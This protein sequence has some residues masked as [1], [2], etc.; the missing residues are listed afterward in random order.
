[1][2]TRIPRSTALSYGVGSIGTGV[3]STVPG[4][5]LLFYLTDLVGVA[6]GVASLVLLLPKL[7]DAVLNPFVGA[8]SD[9]VGARRPFLLVGAVGVPV[10]FALLFSAPDLGSPGATALY[11]GVV[12]LL[13]MTAFAFFQVP[14]VAMPAEMTD[15]YH[16][17][18]RL[19]SV[20]MVLLTVGILVGGALAPALAG[21]KEGGRDGYARMSL[22]VAVVL[23]AAL[24]TAWRGTRGVPTAPPATGPRVTLG[25][26]LRV[27]RGN[28]AF[29][30][31]FTGYALQAVATGAML[32]GAPYVATYVLDDSG[33][34]SVLFVCLV[35]PAALVMPAWRRLSLRTGKLTG[36]LLASSLF[37]LAAAWLV[38][39]RSLPTAGVLLLTAVLG[40]GYAGMQ[41][42]PY[43]MLPDAL[44]AD[45][46]A[47]GEA[48]A[49]TY[50]GVWQAGETIGFAL[51]PALY[52]VTLALSGFTSS[53]AD[54]RVAQTDGAVTGV[55]LGFTLLPAV[56]VLLSLPVLRRCRSADAGHAA[57]TPA[58]VLA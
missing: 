25:A 48:R 22:V 32:A 7:W 20:R 46:S 17:R 21:G 34:A 3:Y 5:L 56:V 18:T 33:L 52:A 15:D 42:F 49:G 14:Y 57:A 54:E 27:V 35:A 43:A 44:A 41:L 16:E 37:A 31:L 8:W 23:A 24:L 47:A 6:A 45:Q 9:R 26:Q 28:P 1:M 10:L 55:V 4:L 29:L 58:G 11:V 12:Y 40:V 30:A 38:L 51:G 13:A 53:P 50:T 39:A 19:M 36:Y 2:A